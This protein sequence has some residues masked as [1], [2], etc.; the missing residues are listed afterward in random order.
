MRT[1][2]ILSQP[3]VQVIDRQA[4]QACDRLMNEA[5]I[6]RAV[7]RAVIGCRQV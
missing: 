7:L 4:E 6:E 5:E 2:A 1:Q 3:E